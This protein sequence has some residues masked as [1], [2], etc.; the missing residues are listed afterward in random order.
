MTEREAFKKL[1]IPHISFPGRKD[2]NGLFRRKNVLH[3][4]TFLGHRRS[5][6]EKLQFPYSTFKP[7]HSYRPASIQSC[8]S[9]CGGGKQVMC[10][11][12]YTCAVCIP[13]PTMAN[14]VFMGCNWGVRRRRG[15]ECPFSSL[16]S[17]GIRQLYEITC[18]CR[19]NG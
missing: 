18:Q 16:G 15:G 17:F 3:S 13:I 1:P 14:L 7:M 8:P 9:L 5:C 4:C 12:V 6:A 19:C 2:K 11:P 10:E